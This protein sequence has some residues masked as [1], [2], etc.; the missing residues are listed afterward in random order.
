M[1]KTAIDRIA[2][3][4]ASNGEAG[5]S[6]LVQESYD[7]LDTTPAVPKVVRKRLDTLAAAWEVAKNYHELHPT[8]EVV[9]VS[10]KNIC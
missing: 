10:K 8:A 7:V 1:L 9:V 4:L 6:K 5:D 3:N 2:E